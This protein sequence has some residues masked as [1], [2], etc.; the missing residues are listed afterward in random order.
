MIAIIS[1]IHGNLSALEAVLNEID[2]LACRQ[3]I[4]LGDIAGYYVQPGECIDLLNERDVI[5]LLGNHDQYIIEGMDC[6]RSRVV[7][8]LIDYQ[9]NLF[10][11]KQLSWL[12]RSR[13]KYQIGNKLFVHGGAIDPVDEYIYEIGIDQ[14]PIGVKFFFSGHTHVQIVAK[15]RNKIYCNPGSVGQPRDGDHRAA[16]AVLE[17]ENIYL[18]RVTYDIG[19]TVIQMKNAGFE[20]KFWENLY[21][22]TQIGGRVDSISIKY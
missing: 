18:H 16:F 15:F 22:G 3:I 20:S 10:S 12:K 11:K 4:F 19:R 8:Q 14:F 9:R 1:D 6:P 17:N 7:S 13:K 5:H 2:K 21:K